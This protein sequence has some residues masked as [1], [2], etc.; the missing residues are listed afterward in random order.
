[1]D[2]TTTC[3]V[4]SIALIVLYSFTRPRKE[5]NTP[6]IIH[7]SDEAL[8]QYPRQA[9]EAAL[10]QHGSVIG[11][12]RKN[13]LEY[14]VDE[15]LA[16]QVLTNDSLFSAERGTAAILN[17]PILNALPYSL[18][19]SLDKLVTKGVTPI[20]ERQLQRLG[21]IFQRHMFELAAKA[22]DAKAPVPVELAHSVH[23]AMAQS[24][25]LLIIGEKEADHDLIAAAIKV[26]FDVAIVAGI[27]QNIG[28]WSRTFP[29]TWRAFIWI[30]LMIF[31]IPWTF[32]RIGWR[33]WKDLKQ[34]RETGKTDHIDPD[35]LVHYL[36]KDNGR[37]PGFTE[38]IWIISLTL[39]ITFASIHQTSAVIVWV[40]YELAVRREY[41]PELR[42]ELSSILET[43]PDTG[44]P[45]LTFASLRNAELLDSF[46]REV[47]RMKG[48]TIAVFRLSTKDA[49]LGGYVIPKGSLITP[50]AT[51]SHENPKNWGEDAN[52]FIGDRWVGTD[53]TAASVSTSY[54]PF[55]L[56]R[57][58]CPGRYLAV[59]E[60]KLMILTLISRVDIFME[61]GK[62]EIIDPLNTVAVPPRGQL[63]FLP[64]EKP[65]L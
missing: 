26:A 12:Y 59:A 30:R 32:R 61:G 11:V 34:A 51:L 48:D 10:Q 41:L 64:L 21:P 9:Y 55:G 65:L 42:K 2:P 5:L 38:S 29:S 15:S 56:G 27:Y 57:F 47:L 14:I 1:M 28:Y 36:V 3:A 13:R 8:F 18:I 62:Y 31:T 35:C 50:I 40:I 46:I 44:K 25:L 17:M 37:I 16:L 22:D 52:K 4:I 60:I 24:M 6:P 33:V 20:L 23:E 53:K 63:L 54:W 45:A 49:P 19:G 7:L 43:D 39:G 58:A